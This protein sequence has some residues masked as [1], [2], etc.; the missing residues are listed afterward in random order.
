MGRGRVLTL[1]EP[2]FVDSEIDESGLQ[3]WR[4][5]PVPDSALDEVA[6]DVIG[7]DGRAL[8]QVAIHRGRQ[9]RSARSHCGG[10]SCKQGF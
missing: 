4:G 7:L 5:D 9:R 8:A 3:Q 6:Q 10:V 1:L 2:A